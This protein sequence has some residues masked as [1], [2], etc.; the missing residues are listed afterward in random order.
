LTAIVVIAVVAVLIVGWLAFLVASSIRNRA[1]EEVPRNVAPGKT[2]DEL[3]SR[4][5]EKVQAAAVVLTGFLAFYLPI[6]YLGEQDRQAGFVEQFDEESLERGAEVVASVGCTDCH[7][8]D[9]SGGGASYVEQRS[10]INVNWAAPALNDIFFRYNDEEVR[11]WIVYGRANTPMPAWGVEGGG[12][13]DEQQVSDVINYLRTQQIDQQAALAKIDPSVDLQ[14][15]RLNQADASVEQAIV[16]QEQLLADIQAAPGQ[17]PVALDAAERAAELVES[18]GEGVDA[19]G[20]GLSDTA[21]TELVQLV[22]ETRAALTPQGLLVEALDPENPQSVE[23]APDAET[24]EAMVTS[25]EEVA[26]EAP[27]VR[28]VAEDAAEALEGAGEGEDTDGDGLS[29][30]AEERISTL[31]TQ[32]QQLLEPTE[33]PAIQLDPQNPQTDG[34]QPDIVVARQAVSALESLATSL[35]V[36]AANQE[37]LT[38]QAQQGLDFL[39][40]AQEEKAWEIDIDAVAEATFDGD[41]DMASRAVGLFNAYCARC[42]TSDWSAGVP[43]TLQ[44]G[45]GGLGPALWNG[46]PNVQFTDEADMMDF[47]IEGSEANVGYGVNGM[48]TGRMPG[49]GQVLQQ[50][51]IELITRYLR[52]STLTG[53]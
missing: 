23:G 34:S 10:G 39:L 45:A 5:L 36:S 19:D 41:T 11:Y 37:R 32:A 40:S 14:L 24:A 35:G 29:N 51:D 52:G 47:L 7:G 13:L 46:R 17:A 15:Q 31:V 50:E 18:G 43:F 44:A 26:A 8:T 30:E 25:L 4:R 9:W 27:A 2:D 42:H 49:F 1:S 28:L 22:N 3:E 53:R 12:P 16:E 33:L 48:G 38:E 21:E 20:D 6:Y